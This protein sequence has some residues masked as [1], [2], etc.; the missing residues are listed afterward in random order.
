MY[1]SSKQ[2]QEHYNVTEQTLR[3]WANKNNI[4]YTKTKG[5]HR[6]YYIE[7]T[8]EPTFNPINVIYARV[9]SRKQRGDLDRQSS[10]LQRKYPEYQLI[11]DIG[12][13]INFN[14]KGFKKVLEG[15]FEGR[16]KTVV[17]AHRDRFTR[18]GFDLFKW[19]FQKQNSI[20]LCDQE[21]LEESTNELTEDILSIITVFTA[22]YYGKR[23]YRKKRDI[24]K[25]DTDLSV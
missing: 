11:T 21:S 23:Q 6:R 20:L 17:V 7:D 5:G 3:V 24:Y 9:S 16:I 1:V 25:K 19:I 4:K 10:F 18:F 12:S 22:R 14:R 15:V 2:A 8:Q 13:G